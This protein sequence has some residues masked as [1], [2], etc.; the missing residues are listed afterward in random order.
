MEQA[1]AS[2]SSQWP[3]WIGV[4]DIHGN[5]E[6]LAAI[7]HIDEAAGVILAGDLTNHGHAAD[8]ARIL[9]RARAIHPNIL[10]QL[11]NMDQPVVTQYLKEQGVNIHRE[12]QLISAG[13]PD[14]GVMGVGASTYTPFGTP[15]EVSEEEMAL[16]LEETYAQA[17]A[18]THLLAV[19]HTP[20]HNTLADDV[21]AGTHVGSKAV[22]AFLERVQPDLC[23]TGHIH[24]SPCEDRL[25][26]TIL[27][28]PGQLSSGGYARIEL[29]PTG[30]HGRLMHSLS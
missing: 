26:K 17:E 27:I 5:I 9:E 2:H 16:W 25:G 13:V 19:I 22:R 7:P 4:G 1:T 15:S 12:S 14:F 20:P 11:G 29:T 24:E 28:N 10:A 18:F 21:G 8:A 23:L 6:P 3:F 30:I